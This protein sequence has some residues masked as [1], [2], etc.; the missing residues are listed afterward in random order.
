MKPAGFMHKHC[1]KYLETQQNNQVGLWVVG[2]LSYQ[3]GRDLAKSRP[4]III[5]MMPFVMTGQM[6]YMGTAVAPG[7]SLGD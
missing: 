5:S 4:R 6:G 7:V 3:V 2:V 1:G